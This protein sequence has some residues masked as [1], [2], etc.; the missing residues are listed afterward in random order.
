LALDPLSPILHTSVGDA[1]FYARRYDEA[2]GWY[3]RCIEM[4]SGALAGHT[5][6]ARALELVGRFDE[7]LAEFELAA[8]LAP[9]GPT[10]PSSGLAC[11]F[12]SMGRHEEAL[13]IVDELV[14]LSRSKYVSP[15]AI[16][17]IYACMGEVDTSLDWMEKAFE[18]HDQTLVWLKV[19]PRLDAL[20]GTNRY[21]ALLERMRL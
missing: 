13:K 3:R 19:H 21:R 4:D 2:M 5:D 6:L 10:D 16:G 14:A 11:V 8:R 20:R 18:A 7:A 9:E 1:Y 12:A 15:Y 17:S